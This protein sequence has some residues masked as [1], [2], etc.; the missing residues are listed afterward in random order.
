MN[1]KWTFFLAYK[2][3][4]TIQELPPFVLAAFSFFFRSQKFKELIAASLAR[5]N[6]RSRLGEGR[7]VIAASY[8][9]LLTT[10]N[11]ELSTTM[12]TEV[13]YVGVIW[14]TNNRRSNGICR[15]LCSAVACLC[16]L[17]AYIFPCVCACLGVVFVIGSSLVH[18]KECQRFAV[19]LML[20]VNLQGFVEIEDKAAKAAEEEEVDD[21][22][23]TDLE[24]FQVSCSAHLCAG[25]AICTFFVWLWLPVLCLHPL[26]PSSVRH[27][28]CPLY[29]LLLCPSVVALMCMMGLFVCQ[30]GSILHGANIRC[31]DLSASAAYL[32]LFLPFAYFLSVSLFFPAPPFSLHCVCIWKGPV[33]CACFA[34]CVYAC[35]CKHACSIVF[36]P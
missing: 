14:R 31:D 17:L 2:A 11:L 6:L 35:M 36:G 9:P 20:S 33:W 10:S 12:E 16:V 25:H 32:V 1:K 4:E 26:P 28:T 24:R 8:F 3:I 30:S 27:L 21:E 13:C 7:L 19:R 18:G 34:V 23:W 29:F 15:I 22:D 5:I